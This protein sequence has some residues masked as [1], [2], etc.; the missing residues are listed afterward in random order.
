M[1]L[2]TA[3]QMIPGMMLPCARQEILEVFDHHCVCSLNQIHVHDPEHNRCHRDSQLVPSVRTTLS[4]YNR[5]QSS[6]AMR[7]EFQ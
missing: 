7:A 2:L 4:V 1:V 3:W 5:N 6:S